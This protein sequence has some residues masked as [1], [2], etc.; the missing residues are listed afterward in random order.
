[1]AAGAMVMNVRS[2]AKVYP[3]VNGA[4]A[5]YCAEDPNF[6][7]GCR[8]QCFQGH[9][10]SRRRDSIASSSFTLRMPP[11]AFSRISPRP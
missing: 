1:M 10:N 6:A 7:I 11:W 9:A 5:G 2:S 4:S 3:F 8:S